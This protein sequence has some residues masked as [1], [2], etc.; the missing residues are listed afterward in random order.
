M[1]SK[2]LAATGLSLL[3]VSV[4]AACGNSKSSTTSSKEYS[5]VYTADPDSLDYITTSR[6]TTS[7]ITSQ[8]IDGLL[9]NDK[10]GNLVPSLAKDWKVSADGLTYTYTLRKGAMWYTSDGEEY[11]EV[12]AQDFV[13]GL[14]HAADKKAEALYVIQDSIKGLNDYVEGKTKDFSTVGIKAVDDYTVQYTLNQ[15]ETYWNS[16]VTYDIMFPVNADFLKSQGKKFG[17]QDPSTILYNGPFI[18]KSMTSK[19][20][21]EFEKNKNYWDAKN[22]KIDKIKLTFNDN[23]DTDTLYKGFDDGTYSIA[24]IFPTK[25]IYKEVKKKYGDNIIFGL[26]DATV[27]YATFNL[28]RST[29]EFTAKSSDKE[30]SDTK[31]AILN[32]DFRQA[33]T[34]GFDR[35]AYNSQSVGKDASTYSLRNTLVPP[36]F[37]STSKGDF[38]SLVTENLKSYGSQ[39]S[40]VNLTD[41]QDGLYN[42]DKAK[43]S[44]EKA[45][46]E[47]QAQGVSFPI[48]L[49]VPVEQ[50]DEVQV[51]KVGSM[52][53]SIEDSLGKENVIIDIKKENHDDY[54]RTSYF[55]Q[56][57]AQEDYDISIASGWSADYA[58]PS[59]YLDIF[60]VKS[61]SNI[62]VIGLDPNSTSDAVAVTG[63]DKYA[64]MLEEAQQITDSLDKRYEAYAKAQALL[65]DSAVVI[66]TISLGGTPGLSR[67]VPFTGAYGLTG[68]KGNNGSVLNFMKITD[69]QDKPVTTK[70][71]ETA[72]EKWLKAK[73]ESNEK[74]Q[75][76]LESHV[77]K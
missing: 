59:S 31:K 67:V 21:I 48:H 47:L 35:S 45:K 42:K 30:K 3:S 32:K 76:E 49:D 4:L 53:Q 70:D 55:A 40:D 64:D 56:S 44:I 69:L 12:K 15:P 2:W 61:G 8:G 27:Y 38:G 51:Q 1:K 26:Q 5:Y 60:S 10:Y 50:T 17:T 18:L 16:K 74:Y 68:S 7:N 62:K 52:K 63:L 14:K 19:S 41:A 73:K 57:A 22:V 39:W 9:E 43:A 58:D 36:T 6:S 29:Y 23:S 11:A 66:P 28:D 54:Y 37:V 25:P 75:K 13:T 72:K 24:K 65:T 77:E 33:I 20:S 34:F 71:Y 46:S